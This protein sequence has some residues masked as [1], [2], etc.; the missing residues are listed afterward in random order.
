LTLP[1]D[2]VRV[3]VTS[4]LA[5]TADLT[6]VVQLPLRVFPWSWQ[7]IPAGEL[8]TVPLPSGLKE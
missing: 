4:T 8:V 7:S 3:K 2:G 5:R 1:G 6:K